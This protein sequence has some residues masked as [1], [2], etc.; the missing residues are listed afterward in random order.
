[1]NPPH[2][3]RPRIILV[4]DHQS[5]LMAFR[6]LLQTS[7]EVVDCVS[8][9]HDAVDAVTRLKPDL[10]VVDLM[11]PDLDGF[12]VHRQLCRDPETSHIPVI[13]CTAFYDPEVRRRVDEAEFD[14]FFEKSLRLDQ[15][16]D[17]I[18]DRLQLA[19]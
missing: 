8:N 15:L 1:M 10:V 7:C 4:D 14:G 16:L 18:R 17:L 12:A 9:G 6:R 2:E 3:R 5:V 11:M 19:Q 13:A